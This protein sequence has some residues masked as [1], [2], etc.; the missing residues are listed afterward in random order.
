[1]GEQVAMMT[2]ENNLE[3]ELPLTIEIP[4]PFCWKCDFLETWAGRT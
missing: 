2:T 1:M 4:E 3:E